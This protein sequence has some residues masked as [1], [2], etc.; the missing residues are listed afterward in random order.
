MKRSTNIKVCLSSFMLYILLRASKNNMRLILWFL[1]H[2]RSGPP[3]WKE[4]MQALRTLLLSDHPFPRFLNRLNGELSPRCRK[5]FISNLIVRGLFHNKDT[6]R[7]FEKR[8]GFF[9]PLAVS[10]APTSRCNL[11]CDHCSAAGQ[12]KQ[13]LDPKLMI[14]VM[15]EAR[16]VM[17]VH[18]F[19]LT[20]GE[21]FIYND[22]FSVIG[23]FRDCY[24]QIFTNGTML[25]EA[26]VKTL[27]ELG[28]VLV[29]LSLE[30][31]EEDTDR[32][33][34]NGV[35]SAATCAM[36]RLHSA[37]VPFGFSVMTTRRNIGSVTGEE[38]I[39][40]AIKH[41]CLLG[42]YLH[43]LPV[44]SDPDLSLLPTPSQRNLSRKNTYR[45]R[46]EKPIFLIDALND[47]PLTGGC[48]SAGKH[49]V[50]ILSSG[51]VTP[52]VYCN[53]STHNI[54]DVSL[55]EALNSPYLTTLRR[56]IPFEGNAL[57]CCMVLDRPGFF[58]R[59]LE[60]FRPRSCIPGEKEKLESMK[61]ELLSYANQ[62]KEIY[63]EAW[64]NGEWESIISSIK[65]SIGN[66]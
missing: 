2:L 10:F 24:F 63:D 42:Y 27:K 8:E 37:G 64:K 40:W 4:K 26:N 52:C 44:G 23:E 13:D 12:A 33:R 38:F 61:P 35:F 30:G 31:F 49:Y 45:W 1:E 56:A 29:M 34:N 7:D 59:T 58:F 15:R 65:W 5:A 53:F 55:T 11:N 47:G 41:G 28:N 39:D 54:K 17:G 57:R 18:F 60:L 9:P 48:T 21:P 51:D 3:E 20:G 19:I 14:R 32:R 6:R 36:Q 25:G 50:H 62:M 22:L 43:Y 46:N 66:C 16:D